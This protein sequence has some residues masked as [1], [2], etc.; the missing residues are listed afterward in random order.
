[1][2]PRAAALPIPGLLLGAY[3]ER[4]E[5]RRSTSPLKLATLRALVDRADGL[6]RR[7]E[8]RFVAQVRAHEAALAGASAESM[9]TALR[10]L[11]IALRRDGLRGAL[12]AQALGWACHAARRTLGFAPFDTQLIAAR[13]VLDNRLAEMATGEG[14]TLA[15]G[16]AAA[17]AALAGIPVHVITANDYLVG[18]DAQTL[19]PL[20][21]A[22]GLTVGAVTQEQ[23]PEQRRAGYACDITYCTAKELVFDYLRDGLGRTRD[24][25]QWRL[26]HLAG[27]AGQPAPRLRGLCMAIVDEAD[28]ILIDEARVPLIL[29]RPVDAGQQAQY[30]EQSLR[31]AAGLRQGVDYH[32]QRE[33]MA[34]ILTAA[35]CAR[36]E[37]E[38]ASLGPVWHNRLHREES[39][40]SAL[41]AL[42]L[43]RRDRHYMVRESKVHIIDE[44][45]GRIAA[46][47]AWSR[48][49][50]Q[51]IELKEGLAPTAP[52][53]T[54]AQITYQRFFPRYLRLGGLS[55]TLAESR[56]ELLAIYG[57]PVRRVP[58]RRPS[59]REVLPGR[60]FA[61]RA[62]LWEAV[63]AR[64]QAMAQSGRPVLVG[65]D[66]V[67]DSASLSRRLSEAGLGH[68]VLDA[69]FDREEAAIVAA[70]GARG[71]ITVAT[72]MAGRGTD[73]QLGA[74]VAEQGGLH[75][76]CCQVNAARRIDRQLAGR[77]ARQGDPGSVETWLSLQSP[78]LRARLPDRLL[79]LLRTHAARLPGWATP[80][81][82]GLLQRLEERR[83]VAQ[84][85]RLLEFDRNLDRRLSF[86]PRH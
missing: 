8:R 44:T 76:V 78:L 77:C 28:S 65:T 73:I 20:Y 17:T 3:P 82:V 14:K 49:L 9:Q 2:N 74:G 11:R 23:S 55:G 1:M 35:G 85:K 67:A 66:S 57:L 10:A 54:I 45:T 58:L 69:R 33:A 83:H 5:P 40:A 30:L 13:I 15:V 42:H 25:L 75:I 29:S 16:L 41:A 37:C 52:F 79:A 81:L 63:A 26:E 80:A 43:Y 21:A 12:L 53:E 51:L 7:G 27:G 4:R 34:A 84:R 39:V 50:H 18:R 70:A 56:T 48:G 38:A 60:L 62:G 72:N 64:V 86:A 19:Q 36:L 71:A 68:A 24:A 22:L 6:Q 59:R 31:I 61:D 47:R 46:G 32:L